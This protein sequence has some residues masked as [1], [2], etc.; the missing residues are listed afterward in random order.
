MSVEAPFETRAERLLDRDR[1]DSDTDVEALKKRERRELDFGMGDAMDRADV[2]IQNTG[3]LAEYRETI[4][5]LFEEG[6]EALAEA[7][8]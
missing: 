3:T 5:K 4:T 6:P 8:A 2:V 1:D 7:D